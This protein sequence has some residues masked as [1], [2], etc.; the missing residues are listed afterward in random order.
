MWHCLQLESVKVAEKDSEVADMKGGTS[1]ARGMTKSSH[2][3]VRI[4][5]LWAGPNRLCCGR[6]PVS[7]VLW[8][9]PISCSRLW[10]LRW[11]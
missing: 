10:Q 7:C 9:V 2:S 4:I 6:G 5:V 8:V 11:M 1:F 3:D